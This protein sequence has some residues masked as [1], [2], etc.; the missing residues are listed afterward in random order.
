MVLKGCTS[1]WPSPV[2]ANAVATASTS[3]AVLTWSPRTTSAGPDDLWWRLC[4]AGAA[5]AAKAKTSEN[6]AASRLS[7]RTDMNEIPPGNARE[8]PHDYGGIIRA[9]DNAVQFFRLR[10]T[11]PLTILRR[12]WA[13]GNTTTRAC[14]HAA[15]APPRRCGMPQAFHESPTHPPSCIWRSCPSRTSDSSST[16]GWSENRSEER[17]VGKEGR[18]RWSPGE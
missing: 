12:Q 6:E 17:R 3:P 11:T 15:C 5:V 9:C 7:E 16:R 14:I 8:R 13:K 18:T 2:S 10:L 1:R 4:L